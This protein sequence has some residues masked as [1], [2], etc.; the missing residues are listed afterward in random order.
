VD[1]CADVKDTNDRS[2]AQ[3]RN[4]E[5]GADPMLR[6]D[7][8]EHVC[9]I[10]PLNDHRLLLCCDATGEPLAHRDADALT[11]RCFDPPGSG[12]DKL[13]GEG[14]N[15][16]HGGCFDPKELP[17]PV[18]QLDQ[19]VLDVEVSECRVGDGLELAQPVVVSAR[20]VAR[21]ARR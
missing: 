1:E 13:L 18:E 4:P 19:K 20:H 5:Q 10:D 2:T 14:I 11:D 16:Q 12:N 9:L 8:I 7:R 3:Q 17:Y 15:Q 21:L 6:K